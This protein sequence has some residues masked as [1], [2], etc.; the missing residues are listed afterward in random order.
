MRTPGARNGLYALSALL[1][2]LLLGSCVQREPATEILVVVH[3]DLAAAALDSVQIRILSPTALESDEPPARE[4]RLAASPDAGEYALPLSFSL[5]PEQNQSRK[6]FR[7]VV[8][9]LQ[10]G[11]AVVEQQRFA[12]F[13]PERAAVLDIFLA[14]S[15]LRLL[16][17]DANG[18]RTNN[19]CAPASSTCQE[20]QSQE[21]LPTWQGHGSEFQGIQGHVPDMD[22]TVSSRADATE[23]PPP[24]DG[25]IGPTD[26]GSD[27]DGD[28]PDRAEMPPPSP[29]DPCSGMAGC[30]ACGK[31]SDCPE[32]AACFM[33]HCDA[34]KGICAPT[35]APV[36]TPCGSGSCD[37]R[38]RCV[39]CLND[40]D[41]GPPGE[42]KLKHCNA[43]TQVCEPV[44]APSTVSCSNGHCSGGVCVQ[45]SSAGECLDR[46][47]H[48]KACSAGRCEYVKTPVGEA[49]NCA[50]GVC[51]AS[52]QC[53]ACATQAQ[54]VH[55]NGLCAE[56]ICSAAGTCQTAAK[57]GSCGTLRVCAGTA[58]V[59]ACDD[60][61]GG[62]NCSGA[63]V[64]LLK[65]NANC[66]K[67]GTRCSGGATCSGGTCVCPSGMHRCGQ[68]CVS[69]RSVDSCG[70]SC[71]PCVPISGG[72]ATCDGAKCG[73]TCGTR[74]LCFN[75]CID[76]TS[77]PSNCGA[78]GQ[79]CAPSQICSASVC[80][81]P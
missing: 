67:C 78:C 59:D 74:E 5:Y 30:V 70:T 62:A 11:E 46:T 75:A 57:T 77:N 81:A 8:T 19:V 45:C 33:K 52:Q 54:C 21:R 58:C 49:G 63:C 31:D 80:R 23:L 34:A 64:N 79:T 17:R 39:G 50:T 48:T 61:L 40:D 24:S 10:S 41:C 37:E 22:A 51:N 12:I 25:Q 53:R 27:A 16:C 29:S 18:Q 1:F 26:G 72:A 38:G 56:G 65:D 71:T 66:G 7:L 3:T 68:A 44:D 20:V 43:A 6:A 42:C 2:A 9:G 76:T 28:D 73:S 4:Y 55:L 15:C 13:D 32:P 60:G 69:D 35:P 36:K 47:C 14:R